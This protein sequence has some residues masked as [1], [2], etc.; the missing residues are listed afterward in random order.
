VVEIERLSKK[1][2]KEPLS[3]KVIVINA[4][5]IYVVVY[6]VVVYKIKKA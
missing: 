1:A 5:R 3:R 2:Q 4:P 6:K